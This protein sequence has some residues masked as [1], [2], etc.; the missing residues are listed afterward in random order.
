MNLFWI[1]ILPVVAI[2]NK[3]N[4]LCGSEAY[5]LNELCG[6]HWF[7][8]FLF[9]LLLFFSSL[10]QSHSDTMYVNMTAIQAAVLVSNK[11]NIPGGKKISKNKNKNLF[12]F[13]LQFLPLWQRR[14][15]YAAKPSHTTPL[16]NTFDLPIPPLCYRPSQILSFEYS[17]ISVRV[18]FKIFNRRQLLCTDIF[19]G[20]L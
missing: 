4:W 20:K 8:F 2:C 15:S 16:R 5:A 14:K 1:F 11:V 10:H 6:A 13:S 18:L 12:A 19:K 7:N 3:L 9:L 17:F